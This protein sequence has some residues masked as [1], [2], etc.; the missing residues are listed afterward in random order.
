MKNYPCLL[1]TGVALLAAGLAHAQTPLAHW[2]FDDAA[3]NTAANTGSVGTSLDLTMFDSTN[4]AAD[5]STA[6][7][8]N[9]IGTAIDFSSASA[10]GNGTGPRAS[11]AANVT[12]Y[13]ALTG[14][15]V[16]G[17]LNT[18][19]LFTGSSGT[20]IRNYNTTT[21]ARGGFQIIT[22]NSATF[23]DG[24]RLVLGT[25]IASPQT[26]DFNI[27]G[28][29][30]LTQAN[31]WVFFAATWSNSGS[32]NLNWYAGD[33]LNAATVAV[34]STTAI[35]T[36]ANTNFGKTVIGRN[37]TNAGG[38]GFDGLLDDIRIYDT[39]LDL[40]QIETI[41]ASA[42]TAIP[43]PSNFAALGGLLALG[44]ATQRRRRRS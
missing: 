12:T 28:N 8:V 34:T 24:L 18:A 38:N 2:T 27:Y 42:L 29:A 22:A 1:A 13:S 43:E 3:G 5:L 32:N 17:W 14:L 4:T 25:G 21:G 23:G 37:D 16:T 41:R 33:T 20:L 26:V 9:G 15:T 10:M 6:T 44:C 35:A 30:T 40:T 7:G 36:I 31:A 19:D 39:A 11:V